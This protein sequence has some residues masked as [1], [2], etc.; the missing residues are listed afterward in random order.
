MNTSVSDVGRI[1]LPAP[2]AGTVVEGVACLRAKHA[3]QDRNGG[4]YLVVDIGHREGSARLKI[5]SS[6]TALWADLSD[7]DALWLSLLGKPARGD[8]PPEWSVRSV[9]KL[10]TDHPIRDDLLPS[11]PIHEDEL[12]RRWATLQAQLSPPAY[13]LL[14][15]VLAHVGEDRY[16]RAS[17]AERM[18]HAVAP[19][20]LWWHSIE[21]AEAALGLARSVPTYSDALSVDVLV[22]GALLHDVGK[23]LEY[24]VLPGVGIRRASMAYARY[25]T[26]LGIQLV[27]EAVTLGRATL[28][29]A[30]TPRWLVDAVLH[31]IESHHAMKEWG[32]PTTPASREAWL[33]HLADM[34][35][36]KLNAL[37]DDLA[38]GTPM[39]DDGWCRPS[40][41]RH[42]PLQ[43]F[44]TLATALR[45]P[46][47]HVAALHQPATADTSVEVP[48]P[49]EIPIHTTATRE[50][51][52]MRGQGAA[53]TTDVAE[54]HPH[55]H[56]WM[57]DPQLLE[58]VILNP[59]NR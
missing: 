57:H 36:A 54:D 49:N 18:H 47:L 23:V 58:V 10:S 35:S 45:A 40:D 13:T 32:S 38:T 25:H 50:G 4:T 48:Q 16:R 28:E 1:A 30:A 42:P 43:R 9:R 34:A 27:T 53:P 17:A 14:A 39:D 12:E 21:V 59:E 19:H 7:G 8:W 29:A 22:L 11:C 3:K 41:S 26:T 51:R 44:D 31:V 15:T 46:R 56:A 2:T 5:W 33:L 37:S 24:D 52:E 55:D 6:E 20:G